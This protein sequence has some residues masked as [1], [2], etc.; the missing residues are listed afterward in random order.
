MI[1]PGIAEA[2]QVADW[3]E[4]QIVGRYLYPCRQ[5]FTD[6][7]GIHYGRF[8]EHQCLIRNDFTSSDIISCFNDDVLKEYLIS[9]FATESAIIDS[10]N[11]FPLKAEHP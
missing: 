10:L 1:R 4:K 8:D 2:K 9:E 7:E 3:E 11:V 5:A 6:L